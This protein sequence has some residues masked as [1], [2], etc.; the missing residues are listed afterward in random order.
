MLESE[1][2]GETGGIVWEWD[3]GRVWEWGVG[4]ETGVGV[5]V[6]VAWLNAGVR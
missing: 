1:I 2:R 6:L 3:K 4:G 5:C